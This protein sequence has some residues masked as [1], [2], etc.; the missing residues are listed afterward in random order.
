MA[1]SKVLTSAKVVL[2]INGKPLGRVTSFR[3]SSD[4][5]W[6]E[7]LGVDQNTPFEFA[8]TTTRCSGSVSLIRTV[9]DGGIE[10]LGM[11]THTS[12]LSRSKYCTL[13][14]VDRTTDTVIFRADQCVV[15]NQSWDA[16]NKGI[17]SG[18]VN[19][20]ALSWSNECS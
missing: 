18:N 4:T 9:R 19:F 14:L 5:P 15:S 3:F 8:P 7:I 20:M 17:I 16:Q 1:K 12:Q 10:A 11:T 6:K 2:Y 13:T